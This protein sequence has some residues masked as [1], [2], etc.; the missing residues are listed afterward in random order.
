[1]LLTNTEPWKNRA[2]VEMCLVIYRSHELREY[3]AQCRDLPKD[4]K[5]SSSSFLKFIL[6]ER[7]CEWSRGRG[8]ERAGR[9]NPSFCPVSAEPDMGLELT[10]REI[11]T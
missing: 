8:R 9:E 2:S 3:G 4:L 7:E 6:K 5:D 11:M 1:M 10:N